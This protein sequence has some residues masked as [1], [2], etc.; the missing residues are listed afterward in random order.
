MES[1]PKGEDVRQ[2]KGKGPQFCESQVPGLP[3]QRVS[4]TPGALVV[5]L[6]LSFVS[7]ALYL[8]LALLPTLESGFY[9]TQPW[10]A[11]GF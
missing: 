2:A 1:Q 3:P 5:R 8:F 7:S 4:R 6:P 9:P 10:R 11:V